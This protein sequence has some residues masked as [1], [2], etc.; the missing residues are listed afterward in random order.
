MTMMG[1]ASYRQRKWWYITACILFIFCISAIILKLYLGHSTIKTPQIII[2]GIDGATW[3]VINPLIEIGRL[4]NFK[5]IIQNGAYG[6]LETIIP[7]LSPIIWTSIAT[8][9]SPLKHGIKTFLWKPKNSYAEYPVGNFQRRAK[10]IWKIVNDELDWKVALINWQAAWPPEEEYVEGAVISYGATINIDDPVFYYP[11]KTYILAQKI[12]KNIQDKEELLF[13]IGDN[14][15][16]DH[17]AQLFLFYIVGID[18]TLHKYYSEIDFKNKYIPDEII[19]EYEKADRM[20]G[21]FIATGATIF[22]VSDHGGESYKNISPE[23]FN[24]MVNRVKKVYEKIIDIN[25][26]RVSLKDGIVILY[27]LEMNLILEDLNL[28]NSS[29]ASECKVYYSTPYLVSSVVRDLFL[30][31]SKFRDVNIESVAK[32]LSDIRTLKDKKPFFRPIILPNEKDGPDIR[33]FLNPDIK[34]N[35]EVVVKRKVFNVSRYLREWTFSGHHLFA[36]K[37]IMAIYGQNIKKDF[38]LKDA[39]IYD[40]VPTILA[41]SGLPVAKDMDGKI[42]KEIFVEVPEVRYIDTYEEGAE[43]KKQ[44]KFPEQKSYERIM[45]ELRSLGYIQ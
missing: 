26:Y 44:F 18:Y 35:E 13:N 15:L 33:V 36:P 38:V 22:V 19:Y 41:L 2:F 25:S 1:K 32:V 14:I 34:L 6:P 12:K 29:Y 37:G 28:C 27:S 43:Y 17:W 23:Q 24:K 7:T 40:V 4:P 30:N 9:K 39:H 16:R 11:K 8:G 5:Y 3:D 10:T 42:L 45:E 21:K 20:L 31:T